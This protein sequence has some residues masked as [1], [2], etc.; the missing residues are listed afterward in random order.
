VFLGVV[1][2]AGL[3]R[4]EFGSHAVVLDAEASPPRLPACNAGGAT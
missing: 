4:K 3:A 2:T 1:L